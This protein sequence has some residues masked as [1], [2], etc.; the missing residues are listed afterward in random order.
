M[1]DPTGQLIYQ[2]LNTQCKR[3]THYTG[4]ALHL[5]LQVSA[6]SRKTVLDAM[7]GHH[8][9]PLDEESQ[10][11]TTFIAEWGRFMYRRMPQGFLASGMH[12]QGGIMT[13]FV[14]CPELWRSWMM[15]C[16]MMRRLRMLSSIH[17]T[18]WPWAGRME[19]CSTRA[20]SSSVRKAWISE[21][22]AL[23]QMVSLH[24]LQ[25]WWQF[26]IFH[27][28]QHHWGSIVVWLG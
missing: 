1:V 27:A 7:D 6:Q 23:L 20:S 12:T 24:L 18:T 11:L 2:Y 22:F 8:S 17:S 15:H 16:S 5:A 4:T 3:E 9:V 28:N 14:M 26:K 25:C 13:L 10:L 19:L 21:G